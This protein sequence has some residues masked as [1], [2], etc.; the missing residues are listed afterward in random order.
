M[1]YLNFKFNW[2][3]YIIIFFAKSGGLPLLSTPPHTPA[4]ESGMWGKMGKPVALLARE[5]GL[6]LGWEV[7]RK[8]CGF[9]G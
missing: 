3:A 7:G 1:I 9:V 2:T 6:D 8:T 4:A 5:G